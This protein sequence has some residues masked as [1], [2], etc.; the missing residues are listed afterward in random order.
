MMPDGLPIE[1]PML[2]RRDFLRLSAASTA[3]VLAG[4]AVNPVTGRSQLMLMSE[5]AELEVDRK[6]SPHQFSADYGAVQEEALNRYVAEIGQAIAPK[7]HRPNMPYNWRAL[8]SVDVNAYTFPAGSM[9]FTRGLLVTLENESELA[10]VMGHE[11]AHV[12]ARHAASAQS[13]GMIAQMIVAGV[14]AYVESEAQGY[15][16]LAAGLGL[17][18]ASALLC[19]YSRDNE[20]EA[21][22][23]GIRYAALA[24]YDPRGMVGVM[25]TF[26]KLQKEKPNVIEV[27][28]ATHPMSQDRYDEAVRRAQ[29]LLPNVPDPKT[30]RERYLDRTSR[31]RAIKPA[32]EEMQKAERLMGQEKFA[33]ADT[34]LR[35][36]LQK[37]PRDY[38]ALLMLAK[39][40]LAQKK[41]AEARRYAEEARAAYPTEPQA[42]HVAG[43]A[44]AETRQFDAAL[45]DF[46][47]YD[48]S[49]PGNP[50]TAYYQGY[51]HDRMGRRQAAAEAYGRYIEEAPDGEHAE[52]VK[53]KLIDWGILKPDPAPQPPP[54]AKPKAQ[55]RAQP[56]PAR[57]PAATTAPKRN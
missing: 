1:E 44:K 31:L 41:F 24:G 32:I 54:A 21:D 50:N 15:G 17:L 53:Q 51:C 19:R 52:E 27:L 38:A 5:S 6:W 4:C 55:P 29:Y 45:A 43:L 23:Y 56:A 22:K 48:A 2:T 33:E 25:D 26:R 20:R 47:A 18:G 9:G 35:T 49:L 3:A 16:A 12:C 7:T 10:A 40:N 46:N 57:K 11:L 42:L 37:A 36:A 39:S 34:H 28:F 8:N 13:K 30:N 14:S